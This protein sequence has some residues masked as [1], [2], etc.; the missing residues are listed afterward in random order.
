MD[1]EAN[2]PGKKKN[3]HRHS[4]AVLRLELALNLSKSICSAQYE[5][6]LGVNTDQVTPQFWIAELVNSISA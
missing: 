2:N 6:N 3:N 5:K 1:S 4:L